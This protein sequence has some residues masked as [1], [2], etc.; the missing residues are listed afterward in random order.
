MSDQPADS[1]TSFVEHPEGL[2]EAYLDGELD[3]NLTR[4][5][6]SHIF[7]CTK[8]QREIDEKQMLSSMLSEWQ[9]AQ[10]RFTEEAFLERLDARLTDCSQEKSSSISSGIR[11]VWRLVPV[12][13]L[14]GLVFLFT[15]QMV[16]AIIGLIPGVDQFLISEPGIVSAWIDLPGMALE[17]IRFGLDFSLIEWSWLNGIIAIFALG[18]AYLGW[19]SAWWISNRQNV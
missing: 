13:L 8:C 6:E 12:I 2:F 15:V 14:F 3:E 5:V 4:L 10:T 17:F 18:L 19:L 16:S 1:I 9:P 11:Y 7:T